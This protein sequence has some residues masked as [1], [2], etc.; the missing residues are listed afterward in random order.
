MNSM[1]LLDLLLQE[2]LTTTMISLVV[3]PSCP[4]DLLEALEVPILLLAWEWT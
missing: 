1:A 4:Q 3:V 2:A